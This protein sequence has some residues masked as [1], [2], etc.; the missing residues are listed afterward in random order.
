MYE[1]GR[2]YMRALLAIICGLSLMLSAQTVRAASNEMVLVVAEHTAY[3]EMT[4]AGL[5]SR[6][7]AASRAREVH[8]GRVLSVRLVKRG[9]V[10]AYQVKILGQDGR[11]RVVYIDARTGDVM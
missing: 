7:H 5:I 8:L 1:K 9:K 10:M 11:V 4:A 3:R 2:G 6:S